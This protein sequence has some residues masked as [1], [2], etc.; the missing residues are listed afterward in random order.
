MLLLA[1][2]K[3]NFKYFTEYDDF[4]PLLIARNNQGFKIKKF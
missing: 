2:K 1:C 4:F 3:E